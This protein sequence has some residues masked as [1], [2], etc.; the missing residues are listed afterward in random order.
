VLF[1][2]RAQR[3]R[4]HLDDKVLT[5]WNGLTIGAFARAARVLP[6]SASAGAY[7][8]AAQRAA[9]FI[10]TTM[11]DRDRRVLLRRYRKGEAGIDAYAEDYAFLIA[12]L[13]DLF[14]ADGDAAW[15]DW[16]L[17]LQDAQDAQFWDAED[18]GWFSTT[19]DDPTV[20]LRLKEDYDGAEPASSSVSVAN[21]LVLS[22][23]VPD[24]NRL[25]KAQRTLA[26]LGDNLGPAGRAVPMML[27]ALSAWHHG[28]I[29]IVIVGDRR[30]AATQALTRELAAR[31]LPF[32]IVVPVEPGG[33]Q[34]V[35]AGRLAFVAGMSARDGAAAYVCRDFT[36]LEP[37]STPEALARLV[38]AS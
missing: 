28:M 37:V 20:L 3:P 23:L 32:A 9:A 1:A 2:A 8:A 10:R 36:C 25:A 21:V 17:E 22:H 19:G 27:C 14:Q 4:P 26:R 5:A 7:L 16:A 30:A 35:L 12:G 24:G 15:L 13:L 18:G 29:Q 31:Y 33:A 6:D 34:E 11:W 38:G